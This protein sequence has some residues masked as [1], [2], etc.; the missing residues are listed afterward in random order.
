[1]FKQS[2]CTLYPINEFI[3]N[4]MPAT[5]LKTAGMGAPNVL[6]LLKIWI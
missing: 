6:Y 4:W 3:S 5:G 1:M 2:N